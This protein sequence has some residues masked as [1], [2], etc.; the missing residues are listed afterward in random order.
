MRFHTQAKVM[1]LGTVRLE[2]MESNLPLVGLAAALERSG[3]ITRI[4]LAPLDAAET[5]TLGEQFIGYPIQTDLAEALYKE[6][7][8]NPLF[9]LEL[10]RARMSEEQKETDSS[11]STPDGGGWGV[12]LRIQQVI[13]E[14]LRLVSSEARELAGIASVLGNTFLFRTLVSGSHLAES[15]LVALLDE[16]WRKGILREQ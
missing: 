5:S 16:L 13:H 1:V 6:S 7:E 10:L 2:E 9:I 12:T 3:Q 8:G 4:S 14:R 11:H 15:K